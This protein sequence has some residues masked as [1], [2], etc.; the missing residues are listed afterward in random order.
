MSAGRDY[1]FAWT[2][3]WNNRQC[4]PTAGAPGA[5]WDD[6]AAT[7]NLFVAHNRMHD[8]AYYLGFTERNWNAQDY[9]FGLTEQSAGERSD[10]RQRAGRRVRSRECVTTR[11]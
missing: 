1:S 5:T 3:D 7:V 8:W 6:S 10:H 2:N 4:E 11:T 9:N